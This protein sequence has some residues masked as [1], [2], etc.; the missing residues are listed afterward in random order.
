MAEVRLAVGRDVV[1]VVVVSAA[2]E[3]QP[4]AVV[5]VRAPVD[6]DRARLRA[7]NNVAR[8]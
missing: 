7:G 6:A 4:A 3:R 5:V 2:A 8:S 1:A